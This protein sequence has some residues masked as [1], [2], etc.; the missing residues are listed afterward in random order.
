MRIG[1]T[2]SGGGHTGYAV[3][4]A[5]RI[6]GKAEMI[7]YIP[8][9]DEWSRIKVQRY[10]EVIEIRKARGPNEGFQKLLTGIPKAFFESIGK[11]K[12]IDVF[13]STGSNHSVPPALVAKLKRTP[14]INI[15]SSVRFTRP[16]SSAKYLS[17]VSDLTVLQWE[18]QK[19]ILPKGRVFGPLYEKPE[20]EV[21]DE[22]YILVTA[23]TYGFKELFD[24]I[25]KTGLE[26]IVL[27][28]GRVDP[29]PYRETMKNWIVFDFDPEINKWIARAS[30]V[31]THLGKTVI[32]SALT[33]KKP[34][35]IIPNPN[36]RLTAGYEDARIL[37]EKLG[38]CYQESLD[39]EKLLD[40]IERCKRMRPREYRDGAEE[41]AKEIFE[42][43]S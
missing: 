13:I 34:T 23:G 9:G 1:I 38:V 36:W 7:F 11:I 24:A 25:V 10:G 39:P 15:E 33:Y 6:Y 2:A 32:D 42:R 28:T 40:A 5:Q 27:Q 22:G 31:I 19:K 35:I 29:R 41:L 17:Y 37:A 30:L 4:L 43:F 8:T 12:N 14:V 26:N 20:Y 21:R 18:E 16:S 3:A